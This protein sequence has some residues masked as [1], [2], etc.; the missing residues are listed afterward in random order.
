M[1]KLAAYNHSILLKI[2]LV[3]GLCHL[4]SGHMAGQDAIAIERDTI[5]VDDFSTRLDSSW[6]SKSDNPEKVY[7]LTSAEDSTYLSAHSVG[8]DDNFLIKEIEVDLVKYPYLNW[9]WRAHTLPE[10]GDESQKQTCDVAASINVVLKAS[11]WRPKT[12]KYSWSSTLKQDSIT[13]SPFAIWPSRCDIIVMQSGEDKLGEW[14]TEKVNVLKHYKQFYKKK[15]VKSV[16]VEAFVIMTD[17]NNTISESA[18]DY[19]NIFFSAH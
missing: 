3:L 2:S 6:N 7:Q 11:K 19:D 13:H 10:N 4:Y 16:K 18:A 15:K 17:S 5:W 1:N 14:V 12:I 9:Q 8:L